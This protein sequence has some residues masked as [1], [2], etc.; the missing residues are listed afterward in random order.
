MDLIV[1]KSAE[2]AS[3]V[4]RALEHH[5]G[6]RIGLAGAQ[7]FGT[8]LRAAPRRRGT[9]AA[10]S[11]RTGSSPSAM[12]A[13][14]TPC[15][16]RARSG[17]HRRASPCA[18]PRPSCTIDFVDTSTPVALRRDRQAAVP[19]R[20]RKSRLARRDGMQVPGRR[21]RQMPC[22]AL[23]AA[24][25]D[26]TLVC[27]WP[28]RAPSPL[29]APQGVTRSTGARTLTAGRPPRGSSDQSRVSRPR[30]ASS[31]L[32]TDRKCASSDF[33]APE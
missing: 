9:G 23:L 8:P 10:R 11:A 33:T 17:T 28:S 7:K 31:G 5:E 1:L 24:E 2:L 26:C 30:V 29:P 14:E 18:R 12:S 19:S 4:R 15:P 20:H 3:V 16:V 13:G 6:G 32:P 21:S 22:S 25:S 27:R